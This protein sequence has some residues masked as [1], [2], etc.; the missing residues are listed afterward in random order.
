MVASHEAPAMRSSSILYRFGLMQ[1]SV[2]A[3]VFIILLWLVIWQ[4]IA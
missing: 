4:V 2:L 3:G 1:R